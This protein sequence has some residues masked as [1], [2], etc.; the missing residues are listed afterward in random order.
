MTTP[1]RVPPTMPPTRACDTA[2]RRLDR[3]VTVIPGVLDH[4]DEQRS[5]IS[6]LAAARA[7]STGG[8]RGTHA[9]PPARVYLVIDQIDRKRGRITDAIQSIWIAIDNLDDA[10]RD[11]LGHRVTSDDLDESKPRCIGDGTAEGANCWNIPSER[12]DPGGRHIDDGRC[13]VCGPRI[14]ARKRA[15]AD[16]RRLRRHAS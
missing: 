9:D 10:C 2:A 7:D 8:Q 5:H 11:A 4:L 14:D 15:E 3:A 6:T 13:H 16:A 12:R 1:P